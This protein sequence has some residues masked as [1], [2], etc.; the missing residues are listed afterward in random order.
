VDETEP[1]VVSEC[2]TGALTCKVLV[3][4]I[5]ATTVIDTVS[6]ISI[7]SSNFVNEN[8]ISK[9]RWDGPTVTVMS[10]DELMILEACQVFIDILALKIKGTC[11]IVKNFPYAFLISNDL[12]QKTPFL[13]DLKKF[14]LINPDGPIV[15]STPLYGAQRL[16]KC[17]STDSKYPSDNLLADK[18]ISDMLTE[19]GATTSDET[20][21]NL[22]GTF[23]EFEN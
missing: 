7:I 9:I 10:G 11:G 6:G 2:F 14:R 8:N 13:I 12:L 3:N 5:P 16:V 19:K 18:N 21:I 17:L 15:L 20:S 22:E 1:V 23:I 4:G